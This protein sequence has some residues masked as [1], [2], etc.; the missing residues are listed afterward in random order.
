MPRDDKMT[1]MGKKCEELRCSSGLWSLTL[2]KLKEEMT[3]SRSGWATGLGASARPWL[4]IKV[5]GRLAHSSMAEHLFSM[6]NTVCSIL[7]DT[8]THHLFQLTKPHKAKQGQHY[9]ILAIKKRVPIIASI[10]SEC[11]QATSLFLAQT[12]TTERV[13]RQ[14]RFAKPQ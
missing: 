5:K 3:S 4:K 12:G 6:Q 11:W 1:S 10:I 9:S 13:G 7:N 14:R 2:V 8:H